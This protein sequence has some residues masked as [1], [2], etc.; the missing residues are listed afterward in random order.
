MP[1][2]QPTL[3]ATVSD[4][5]FFEVAQGLLRRLADRGRVRPVVSLGPRLRATSPWTAVAFEGTGV[6]AMAHGSLRH[7]VGCAA[8]ILSA[9]A[10]LSHTDPVAVPKRGR[11]REIVARRSGTPQLF[12]QHGLFQVG[13]NLA[14]GGGR[15][16]YRA[17]RL[18]LWDAPGGAD[19]VLS[20][21]A[22][23]RAARVGYPKVVGPAPGAA[24]SAAV[25]RRPGGTVLVCHNFGWDDVLHAE[26]AAGDF[27]TLMRDVARRHSDTTFI[28]RPHRGRMSTEAA[29]RD[30][31]LEAECPN[32]LVSRREGGPFRHSTIDEMLALVDRVVTVPSTVALD[33]AYRDRPVGVLGGGRRALLDGLPA[34][35]SADDFSAFLSGGAGGCAP[36]AALRRR[37][38]AVD[39]NLDRAARL[40]EERLADLAS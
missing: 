34:I 32:V 31:A 11:W 12:L 8:D 15:F 38:G 9:T 33:A 5:A 13:V 24:L 19:C 27:A 30:A 36:V 29:R 10:V 20:P 21:D 14:P 37:F 16:D 28:L 22:A 4:L 1:R 40:V 7:K 26:G 17:D 39:D 3:Y 2:R 35:A 6:Q 23:G 18:L 25:P